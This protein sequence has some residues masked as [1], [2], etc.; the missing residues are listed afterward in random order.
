MLATRKSEL[1]GYARLDAEGFYS[2]SCH[3][4]LDHITVLSGR[5]AVKWE[6]SAD[7]GFNESLLFAAVIRT[8]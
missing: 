6:R 7:K 5:G 8:K 1:V 4:T 3:G 2:W